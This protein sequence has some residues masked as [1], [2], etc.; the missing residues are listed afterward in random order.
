MDSIQPIKKRALYR[1]EIKEAIRHAIFSGELQPGDRIVE[2]RWAKD[3][4]VSQSPVR[5]AIRELEIVGLIEN[6]PYQG[7]F[8]R[9][10][11]RKDVRDSYLVRMALEQLGT[12]DACRLISDE[13]LSA[14]KE[15]LDSM[16]KAAAVRDFDAY[17]RHDVDFHGR[18]MRV[19]PNEMLL[20]LWD[21]CNI[22]EWTHFGTQF[23]E[24]TLDSLAIRHERIYKAL[25][26]RNERAALEETRKHIAE[27]VEE[28]DQR[29][30]T[31]QN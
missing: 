17:I 1:D 2:T 24:Q 22:R 20:R 10:I 14:V 9:K 4:G 18:I 23:S 3:L 21:Q 7:S 26:A 6:I 12:Q 11:T 28:L 5:E 19:S 8:V 29:M 13:Q 30:E 15:S 27:L 25:A 16:E 31:E